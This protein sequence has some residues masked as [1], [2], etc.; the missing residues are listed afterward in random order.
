MSTAQPISSKFVHVN[1]VAEKW[2]RLAEFYK[3]VFGCIP[4]PPRRNLSGR[5]LEKATKIKGAEIRG[6]Q[7]RLPGYG[8]QG[9]MI[10]I[11]TYNVHKKR[12]E[13]SSNKL[14]FGHIA[15]SVDDVQAA[16]EAVLAAGG[17]VLGDL[18]QVDIPGLGRIKFVYAKDPEGNI[19]ELQQH[20]TN[21]LEAQSS[22]G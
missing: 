15:F 12:T 19:I 6:V 17:G 9:P 14:G 4:V 8:E 20:E 21:D 18:V 3:Q 1:I 7:L 16:R 13:T 5:W 2:E 22:R 10:E 11:F